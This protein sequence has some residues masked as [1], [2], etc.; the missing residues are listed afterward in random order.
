MIR[1]EATGISQF[2]YEIL[3]IGDVDYN[4]YKQVLDNLEEI[5]R[6]IKVLGKEYGYEKEVEE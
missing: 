3:V 5:K 2:S 6:Q 4:E 1:V